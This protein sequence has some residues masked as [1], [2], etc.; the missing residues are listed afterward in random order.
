[1]SGLTRQETPSPIRV[2][3]HV[4]GRVAFSAHGVWVVVP[5]E[6]WWRKDDSRCSGEGWVELLSA[7]PP[8]PDVTDPDGEMVWYTAFDHIAAFDGRLASSEYYYSAK[9]LR[10]DALKMLAAVAAIEQHREGAR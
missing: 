8:E 6:N 5:G 4:D 1:M 10:A 3:R 9:A 7:E 2:R